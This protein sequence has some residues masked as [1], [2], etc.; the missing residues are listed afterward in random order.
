MK[1]FFYVCVA[2]MNGFSPSAWALEMKSQDR[3][4]ALV[5]YQNLSDNFDDLLNEMVAF[6][7]LTTQERGAIESFLKA[8]SITKATALTKVSFKE[9][10]LSWGEVSLTLQPDGTFKTQDGKILRSSKSE[11]RDLVFKKTFNALVEKKYSIKR[12]WPM[13]LE[14]AQAES[15][16]EFRHALATAKAVN[17]ATAALSRTLWAALSG[18]AVPIC[19]VSGIPLDG[20][21][22]WMKKLIREGKVVCDGRDYVM[23]H[24][25]EFWKQFEADYN[26]A[27]KRV[28]GQ[29][30]LFAVTDQAFSAACFGPYARVIFGDHF[31]A[32]SRTRMK[33][34]NALDLRDA[35]P[36]KSVPFCNSKSVSIAND[37]MK[38]KMVALRRLLDEAAQKARFGSS[39]LAPRPTYPGASR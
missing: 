26:E 20:I 25:D 7:G 34:I 37:Y 9:Q 11:S 12:H 1:L 28:G 15:S 10:T 22:W 18:L 33:E 14:E 6:G 27:L 36:D 4:A 13:F 8:Q 39:H 17:A 31:K 16:I 5:Q 35:F 19:G 32:E 21:S 24:Y 30:S 3:L 38:A 29:K 23:L 2:L